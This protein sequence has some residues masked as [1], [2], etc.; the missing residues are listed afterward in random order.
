MWL[1]RDFGELPPEDIDQFAKLAEVE[2]ASAGEWTAVMRTLPEAE[3]KAKIASLLGEPV[4]KD[5]GGERNDLYSGN[6]SVQG[7]RRTAAF[8]VKAYDLL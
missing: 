4:K 1:G 8:L 3:V 5:W 2:V 7:R 6:V